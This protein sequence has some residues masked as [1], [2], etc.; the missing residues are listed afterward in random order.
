[1]CPKLPFICYP[2]HVGNIDCL[3]LS[4]LHSQY[5]FC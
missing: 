2:F 3:I 5:V 1:M 4:Y